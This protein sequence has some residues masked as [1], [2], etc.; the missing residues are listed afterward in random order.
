MARRKTYKKRKK[1]FTE[2]TEAEFIK[3]IDK[4]IAWFK[5]KMVK[6]SEGNYYDAHEHNLF[7][8]E[9]LLTE[10]DV[11]RDD[12][13]NLFKVKPFL[14]DKHYSKLSQYQEYK[15]AKMG[16]TNRLNPVLVKF[17][18]SNKHNWSDK[19][20]SKNKNT[21]EIKDVDLTKLVGF[22]KTDEDE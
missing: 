13:E 3:I 9:F 10:E 11:S 22:K 15:L 12:L 18:L 17:T 19:S 4:A 7:M 20:E 8:G 2:T 1:P 6:D 5:P 14:K 16:L 21:H